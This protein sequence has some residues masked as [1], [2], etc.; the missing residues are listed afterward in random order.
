MKT[1]TALILSKELGFGLYA[2]MAIV[3]SA[4]SRMYL[5]TSIAGIFDS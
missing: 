4:S 1:H 3:S 5:V 2:F